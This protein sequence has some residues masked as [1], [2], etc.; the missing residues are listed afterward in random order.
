MSTTIRKLTLSFSQALIREPILHN[1]ASKFAV[2]FNISQANVT[3]EHG[4]LV[5]SL[6]GDPEAIEQAVEYMIKLGVKID[7]D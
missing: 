2:T 3:D 7:E 4:F 1:I 5:I 6:E